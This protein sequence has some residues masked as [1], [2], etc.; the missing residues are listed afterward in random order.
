[1]RRRRRYGGANACADDRAD[2]MAVVPP[3]HRWDSSAVPAAYRL[4]EHPSEPGAITLT[5]CRPHN[6]AGVQLKH[7]NV[8]AKRAE[9]SSPDRFAKQDANAHTEPRPDAQSVFAPV[10]AAFAHAESPAV[11][12]PHAHPDANA[13]AD[14]VPRS[15][16]AAVR[17]RV[18]GARAF[19]RETDG[20]QPRR[21]WAREGAGG[22]ADLWYILDWHDSRIY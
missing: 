16:A 18:D 11:G 10:R 17:A 8:R 14:A 19:G 1:M 7:S 21:A 6:G 4:T 15:A 20:Q 2:C 12:S 22:D 9:Y 5:K 13:L 3:E